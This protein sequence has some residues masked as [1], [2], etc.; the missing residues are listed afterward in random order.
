LKIEYVNDLPAKAQGSCAISPCMDMTN[1][2]FHGL[3]VSPNAPQDDVLTMLA[4]PGQ[5]LHYTVSIPQDHPPGLYWYHTHPHGESHGQ[6]RDGMSGAIVIEGMERYVPEVRD[7]HEQI[8]VL[9]GQ[10]ISHDSQA[11]S[12]LEKARRFGKQSRGR[13]PGDDVREDH[14]GIRIA[15]RSCVYAEAAKSCVRCG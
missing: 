9:R 13:N 4:T 11:A 10:T 5:S 7:L 15:F 2:H 1:L 6:V 12:L 8:F 3:Q 14:A